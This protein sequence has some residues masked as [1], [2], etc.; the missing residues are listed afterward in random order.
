MPAPKILTTLLQDE[1]ARFA[2]EADLKAYLT[3]QR[4]LYDTLP[5]DSTDDLPTFLKGTLH[6]TTSQA[7]AL[8]HWAET[9]SRKR[10]PLTAEDRADIAQRRSGRKP[11]GKKRS[12]ATG[13]RETPVTP[14]P[15]EQSPDDID[16]PSDTGEITAPSSVDVDPVDA[17]PVGEKRV[18]LSP[19]KHA[20]LLEQLSRDWAAIDVAQYAEQREIKRQKARLQ[21]AILDETRARAAQ[22]RQAQKR[23]APRLLVTAPTD[24][25]VAGYLPGDLDALQTIAAHYHGDKGDFAYVCFRW[26]NATV[27]DHRLPTTLFQWALTPYGKCIGNTRSAA[28]RYPIITLHPGIWGP[29]P[30][31]WQPGPRQTLDTVIH[32]CLHVYMLY[33]IGQEKGHSS[34]DNPTWISECLRL[35]PLLG[36]PAFQAAPTKRTWVDGSYTR[37]TPEGCLEMAALSRFPSPLRPKGYY[38]GTALPWD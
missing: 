13:D 36:L 35:G 15:P 33:V 18:P 26:V 12:R 3:E 17:T 20:E 29:G 34:H 27:F 21:A 2:S 19:E 32:E 9:A 1:N 11:A 22:E 31:E 16:A 7:V 25:V 6:C 37:S 24:P 28:E 30:E 10:A 8:L 23:A 4:H 5:E 38:A 14:T